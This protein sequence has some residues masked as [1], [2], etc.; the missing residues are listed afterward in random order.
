MAGEFQIGDVVQ[1]KSG[2][3]LMTVN[4]VGE[5]Y[6]VPT[7]FCAWFDSKENEKSSGFRPELLRKVSEKD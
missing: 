4:E 6:G 3:P 7:V 2:G 5:N 1:L